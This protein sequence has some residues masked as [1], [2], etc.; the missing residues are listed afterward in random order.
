MIFKQIYLA[1]RWNPNRYKHSG[2]G[3]PR[4]NGNEGVLYTP[5]IFRTGASPSDVILYHIQNSP[6]LE[7]G[8]IPLCRE[9]S[10]YIIS[11]ADRAWQ[12]LYK[13]I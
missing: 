4:S 5:Q 13:R 11:L 9:Y 2:Q 7:G 8:I 12:S 3:R 6:F 10:Q 1:Y